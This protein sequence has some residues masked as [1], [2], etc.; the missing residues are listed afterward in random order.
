MM[1]KINQSI[2]KLDFSRHLKSSVRDYW[3]ND[4]FLS[5]MQKRLGLDTVKNALDIGCGLGSWTKKIRPFLAP[6][7]KIIGVDYDQNWIDTAKQ[8][9]DDTLSFQT[10]DAYNLPFPDESFDFVTCQTVLMH[11]DRPKD[12]MKEM[13][14]VLKKDGIVF[15]ADANNYSNLIL[16]NSAHAALTLE[17]RIEYA[18]LYSL[19]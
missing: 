19:L 4:D 7:A 1:T 10:G 2:S 6:H 12:A 9:N 11:L 3:W 15:I 16:S 14:R 5:L 18:R 8:F 17:E 13:Y